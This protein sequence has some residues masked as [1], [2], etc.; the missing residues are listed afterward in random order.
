M[1]FGVFGGARHSRARRRGE[2]ERAGWQAAA[3]TGMRALPVAGFNGG[4]YP[5]PRQN[6]VD[7]RKGQ[8]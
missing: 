5:F 2:P 6:I 7:K 1:R 4:T 8:K 3:R